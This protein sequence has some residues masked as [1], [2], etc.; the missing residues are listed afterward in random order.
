MNNKLK[1]MEVLLYDP[2]EEMVSAW[3]HA[4]SVLRGLGFRKSFP[5]QVMRSSLETAADQEF[6]CVFDAVVVSSNSYGLLHE[7]HDAEVIHLFRNATVDHVP[8][9]DHLRGLISSRYYGE[10]P[11]GSALAV[12]SGVPMHPIVL[13]APV[14]TLYEV[15]SRDDRVYQAVRAA[16]RTAYAM[17]D[18]RSIDRVLIPA[19]GK[20]YGVPVAD[21]AIQTL[22]ALCSFHNTAPRTWE[23]AHRFQSIMFTPMMQTSVVN[24]V[25]SPLPADESDAMSDVDADAEAAVGVVPEVAVTV[26]P[27][28]SQDII[29]RAPNRDRGVVMRLDDTDGPVELGKR[30]ASDQTPSASKRRKVKHVDNVVAALGKRTHDDDDGDVPSAKRRT[31]FQAD[32]AV[33][34]DDSVFDNE[35]E[36]DSAFSFDE[37]DMELASMCQN[38]E[39]DESTPSVLLDTNVNQRQRL[40]SRRSIKEKTKEDDDSELCEEEEEEY[41]NDAGDE[42]EDIEDNEDNE[43]E[44][45]DEDEEEEEEEEEDV[46]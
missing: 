42:E 24:Q 18:I 36:D 15:K 32:I 10:L 44:D 6:G 46:V 27:P 16:I 3:Q 9:V 29:K 45:E 4:W 17:S 39:E 5:C 22:L 11:V 30:K 38:D 23:D 31:L 19:V 35:S 34:S 37:L 40:V 41:D 7:R 1:P 8:F 13:Y 25:N 43:D 21:I 33:S 14:T 28:P 2:D 20:S 12:N 26:T